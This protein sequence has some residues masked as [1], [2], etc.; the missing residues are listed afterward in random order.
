MTDNLVITNYDNFKDLSYFIGQHHKAEEMMKEVTDFYI[1]FLKSKLICNHEIDLF[2]G[3]VIGERFRDKKDW[4]WIKNNEPG[5]AEYIKGARFQDDHGYWF[6]ITKVERP[7]KWCGDKKI[8][9]KRYY[10][11]YDIARPY[12]VEL[13][14]FRYSTWRLST[15][16]IDADIVELSKHLKLYHIT[17]SEKEAILKKIEEKK[18][19]RAKIEE[20]EKECR[21]ISKL[22]DDP[23][24]YNNQ[25]YVKEQLANYY[26]KYCNRD[27]YVI[28]PETC[29]LTK[30]ATEDELN[31]F[32]FKLSDDNK[33]LIVFT[34]NYD[35]GTRTDRWMTFEYKGTRYNEYW[36]ETSTGNFVDHKDYLIKDWETKLDVNNH[37]HP[38]DDD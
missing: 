33:Y 38:F 8:R 26:K 31:T 21:R 3:K 1:S 6:T 12:Y 25:K 30:F 7:R 14:D 18:A 19:E 24:Q 5:Y 35:G 16:S 28:N 13:I 36:F 22:F 4:S 34:A 10:K 29:N 11:E 32:Q 9:E 37:W 20:Q 2:P 27:Y 15:S 17:E 23:A